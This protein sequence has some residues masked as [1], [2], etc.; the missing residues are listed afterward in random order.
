MKKDKIVLS[1][2]VSA[3]VFVAFIV[4]MF[5]GSKVK[6]FNKHKS[7]NSRYVSFYS[8]K[9]A[10]KKTS[11]SENSAIINLFVLPYETCIKTKLNREER[12]IL[13]NIEKEVVSMSANNTKIKFK[14]D[15]LNVVKNEKKAKEVILK[16]RKCLRGTYK[17]MTKSE[18]KVLRSAFSKLSVGNLISI[19]H[20]I[21]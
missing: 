17:S 19:F 6:V 13:S 2:V 20:G 10:G 15:D 4:G 1:A 16:T 9:N 14:I 5:V 18:K 11:E 12:K 21:K 8:T 3:S 7:K